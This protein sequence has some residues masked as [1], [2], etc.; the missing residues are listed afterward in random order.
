MLNVQHFLFGIFLFYFAIW[1]LKPLLFFSFIFRCFMCIA[2]RGMCCL[3]GSAHFYLLASLWPHS[4]VLSMPVPYRNISENWQPKLQVT[5]RDRHSTSAPISQCKGIERKSSSVF[6]TRKRTRNRGV[7]S[8]FVIEVQPFAD[9]PKSAKVIIGV[10]ALEHC[11]KSVHA[12]NISKVFKSEVKPIPS[13]SKFCMEQATH[14]FR[15]VPLRYGCLG[16]S[17]V[18]G[19]KKRHTCRI[20]PVDV[21]SACILTWQCKAYLL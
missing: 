5:W 6:R 20:L 16:V 2:G 11:S 13:P 21:C 8:C 10:H 12:T 15:A 3:L 18:W 4:N 9:L 7:A 17:F 14:L 19:I 1:M